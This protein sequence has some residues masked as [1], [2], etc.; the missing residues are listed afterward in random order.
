M[1]ATV[2]AHFDT[3]AKRY[4]DNMTQYKMTGDAAA[5]TAADSAKQWMMYYIQWQERVIR[6]NS[7]YINKFVTD[8]S[9][10]NKDLIDMQTKV[11][12]IKT[13]GP[14][15]EDA[16]LTSKEAADDTPMD[17]TPYYVKGGIVLGTLVLVSVLFMRD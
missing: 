7:N 12:A 11:R 4:R 10:T 16:Y 17:F 13:E 15:L 2:A 14:K 1:A 6:N 9:T 5:K 3:V 8:Y